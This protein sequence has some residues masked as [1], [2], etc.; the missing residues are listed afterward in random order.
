[1]VISTHTYTVLCAGLRMPITR[2]EIERQKDMNINRVVTS[3][4]A[5]YGSKRKRW[6]GRVGDAVTRDE[7]VTSLIIKRV[8]NNETA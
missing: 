6:I 7:L 8:F 4:I 2:S 1:M 3:I 5:L